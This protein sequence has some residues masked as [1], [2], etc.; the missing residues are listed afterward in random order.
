[1]SVVVAL[2]SQLHGRWAMGLDVLITILIVGPPRE[3]PAGTQVAHGDHQMYA[4]SARPL[5]LSNG[6]RYNR[7]HAVR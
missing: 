7:D 2:A 6:I 5:W 4:E 1:M 3:W